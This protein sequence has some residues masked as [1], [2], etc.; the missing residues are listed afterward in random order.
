MELEHNI[1]YDIN[2]VTLYELAIVKQFGDN[3][4]VPGK[5]LMK[6]CNLIHSGKSQ[7]IRD[8]DIA[9]S[10]NNYIQR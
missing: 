7:W 1:D 5:G 9:S 4:K 10:E 3:D 8:A 2:D 6:M